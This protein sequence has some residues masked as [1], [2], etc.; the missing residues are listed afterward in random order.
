MENKQSWIVL[1]SFYVSCSCY[2]PTFFVHFFFKC[3]LFLAVLGLRCCVGFCLVVAIRGYSLAA[4]HGLLIAVASC[5]RAWGLGML[6]QQLWFTG[7]V[8]LQHVEFSWTRNQTHISCT[9]RF[10]TTGSPGKSSL[11][12]LNIFLFWAP[13]FCYGLYL[14]DGFVWS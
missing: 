5:C 1:F 3:Y 7:L 8:T 4:V 2:V 11:Q 13:P 10:L 12:L 9:G 6:A 14:P